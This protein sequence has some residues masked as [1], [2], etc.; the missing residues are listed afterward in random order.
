GEGYD[1]PDQI[2]PTNVEHIEELRLIENFEG[3]H[4]WAIGLDRER[5]FSVST[6]SDPPRIVID[7]AS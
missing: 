1:G 2:I 6:L 3:M 4:Q 5:P 7:I